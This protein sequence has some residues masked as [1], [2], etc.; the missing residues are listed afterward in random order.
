MAKLFSTVAICIS[1]RELV[2]EFASDARVSC[3]WLTAGPMKAR[4]LGAELWLPWPT[5]RDDEKAPVICSRVRGVSR[6]NRAP[7]FACD[8]IPAQSEKPVID[9]FHSVAALTSVLIVS[10][11][12][13]SGSV[14]RRECGYGPPGL[15][16]LERRNLSIMH[17]W[18]T[19][20]CHSFAPPP[21]GAFSGSRKAYFAKSRCSLYQD[22]KAFL[23]ES[24]KFVV[25]LWIFFMANASEKKGPGV[26]CPSSSA[27]R[28]DH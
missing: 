17:S 11:T 24:F 13:S 26:E 1:E 10:G 27:M 28:R 22:S 2:A 4:S 5:V 18:M 6:E 19:E 12:V 15:V 23:R 16:S 25:K 14:G 9:C 3:I 21:P 8:C 7:L 20:C